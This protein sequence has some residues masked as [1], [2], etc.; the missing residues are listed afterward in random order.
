METQLNKILWI[1]IK[2]VLR[3]DIQSR[4]IK[5][6]KIRLGAIESIE[7]LISSPLKTV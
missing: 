2:S 6:P 3:K 4:K 1:T 7:E 5:N